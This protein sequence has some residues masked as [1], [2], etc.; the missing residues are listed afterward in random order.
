MMSSKNDPAKS[1]LLES[2]NENDTEFGT[3]RHSKP[4]VSIS[5]WVASMSDN[6]Q[7]VWKM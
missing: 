4:I 5:H 1:H 3:V 7:D 6:D 2:T